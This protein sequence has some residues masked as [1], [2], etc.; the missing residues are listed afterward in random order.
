[1]SEISELTSIT[2][3]RILTKQIKTEEEMRKVRMAV[4][5]LYKVLQM[6]G[7]KVLPLSD[8]SPVDNDDIVQILFDGISDMEYIVAHP[9]PEGADGGSSLAVPR[10]VYILG[11]NGAGKS[12]WG[13]LI[14]GRDAKFTF[15][16]GDAIHTT[17]MPQRCD[18]GAD[19]GFRIWDLP[20]LYDGT[21]YA[22]AVQDHITDTIKSYCRYVCVIFIFHGLRPPDNNT[23]NILKYTLSL[24]RP[25]V[26]TSILA[27]VN[28]FY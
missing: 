6:F 20:G 21:S 2:G 24:F 15:K 19:R 11:Q 27:I 12:T 18:V 7:K 13:N 1:M 28:N 9:L 17:L 8:Q 5:S 10:N 4:S 3:V 25:S 16:C 14:A 23:K 22:G 26:R